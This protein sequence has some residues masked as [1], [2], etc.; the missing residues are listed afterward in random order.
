M[1][2]S[3]RVASNFFKPATKHAQYI[4]IPRTD[5]VSPHA[6]GTGVA[7]RP[8]LLLLIA[9]AANPHFARPSQKLPTAVTSA[10]YLVLPNTFGTFCA[11]EGTYFTYPG[12]TLPAWG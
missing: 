11:P 10:A 3:T 1:L 8:S 4:E 5:G 2:L 6:R 9:P 12:L 7:H